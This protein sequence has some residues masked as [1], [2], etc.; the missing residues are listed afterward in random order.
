MKRVLL[1]AWGAAGLVAAGCAPSVGPDVNAAYEELSARAEAYHDALSRL[2][3]AAF[4]DFYAPD[5]VMY[6][7]NHVMVAGRAAIR[8]YAEEVFATPGLAVTVE[9]TP[10]HMGAA[11]D[12]G[13]S[14]AKA[15]VTMTGPDGAPVSD[16]GPDVHVWRRQPAGTWEILIDIW[17]SEEPLPE[18]DASAGGSR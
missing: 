8:A 6:P 11:A 7:P 9:T 14:T 18:P 5:A 3:A 12:I 16:T 2:D 4:A 13:Y 10:V 1:L 17:N 15:T